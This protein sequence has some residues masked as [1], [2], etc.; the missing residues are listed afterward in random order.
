MG[1]TPQSRKP[2]TLRN[3]TKGVTLKNDY[4]GEIGFIRLLGLKFG[5][6]VGVLESRGGWGD[7]DTTIDLTY[8]NG[9]KKWYREDGGTNF[10]YV[11][12]QSGSARRIWF[13]VFPSKGSSSF[14]ILNE[15]IDDDAPVIWVDC[16]SQLLCLPAM[17]FDR[18]YSIKLKGYDIEGGI[19][20]MK[21]GLDPPS[22]IIVANLL[23]VAAAGVNQIPRNMIEAGTYKYAYT[24]SYGT[25]DKPQKY[26]ESG[27]SFIS[28]IH[29]PSTTPG[30]IGGSDKNG[31]IQI[32][33]WPTT[34]P[35][36]F[37]RRVNIYRSQKDLVTLYKIGEMIYTGAGLIN[38]FNDSIGDSLIDTSKT[39][40]TL[41][42]LP[43]TMISAIW[44]PGLQ[45]LFWWGIDGFLHWSA[46]SFPDINP[47]TNKIA[48][49]HT[50]YL[51]H[52]FAIIRDNIYGFKEDGI[53]LIAGDSP[54]YFS[55][56]VSSVQCFS[57]A[58][59]VEMPDGI[60][61]PGIESGEL[62]VY[63]FD[64]NNATP[65]SIVL[66][67]LL[68]PNRA[69]VLKKAFGR[70]VGSEYWLSLM[71]QDE[72]YCKYPVPFNNAIFAYD[73][74]YREWSTL[75]AQANAIEVFDGPGDRGEIFIVESDPFNS[76]SKGTFFR[77]EETIGTANLTYYNGGV[78][79]YSKVLP[80]PISL[81]TEVVPGIREEGSLEKITLH[82]L[83]IRSRS[84]M[85]LSPT[86]TIYEDSRVLQKSLVSIVPAQLEKYPTL[87]ITGDTASVWTTGKWGSMIWEENYLEEVFYNLGEEGNTGLIA[88]LEWL[89]A[90]I[91]S[92]F[93]LEFKALEFMVEVTDQ[94]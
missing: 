25:Y 44:H 1:R 51:G 46:A 77:L 28:E 90:G 37:V 36:L 80:N 24:Y 61:F 39:A 35:N 13:F 82:A 17:F 38:V 67:S 19:G 26:G 74:R 7:W 45:R 52:G 83:K 27:L 21:L 4:A 68:P 54:N 31:I 12:T 5:K 18:P 47:T 29:F 42:G 40:P 57:T 66:D 60:Y 91:Y 70:R 81:T 72:R 93:K 30:Y 58:G 56:K 16:G 85:S 71:I 76:V 86:L 3:F 14:Q 33:G 55:K 65:I 89:Y 53:F 62:R 92:T 2:I 79:T 10:F 63:R 87:T 64:G 49:G 41:V 94:E 20:P 6:E 88:N 8:I 15:I 9:L 73:Y 75:F 69:R 32:T 84:Q 11:G 59:V 50:G 23:G 78:R 43:S 48:V 22:P 34:P